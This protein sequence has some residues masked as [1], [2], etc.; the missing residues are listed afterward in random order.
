LST[1]HT[2]LDIPAKSVKLSAE[3]FDWIKQE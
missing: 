1:N 2:T 3:T